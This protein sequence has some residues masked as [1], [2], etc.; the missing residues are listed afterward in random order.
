MIEY[1]NASEED[2]KRKELKEYEKQ[3]FQ[4]LDFIVKCIGFK[5]MTKFHGVLYAADLLTKM[6]SYY[7]V[8]SDV[9]KDAIR[10]KL[11]LLKYREG[12]N[13]RLYVEKFDCALSTRKL[14]VICQIWRK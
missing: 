2:R 9:G 14:V 11:Q 13:M 8:D 3:N 4:A 12:G 10:S 6:D 1:K 7:K 5:T